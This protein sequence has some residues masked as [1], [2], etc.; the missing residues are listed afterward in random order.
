MDR[1]IARARIILLLCLFTAAGCSTCMAAENVHEL[2]EK[3]R[4]KADQN[5][6]DAGKFG[7]H[8]KSILKELSGDGKVEKQETKTF[9]TIW[10]EDKAYMELV[11]IDGKPLDTK[12]KKEEAERRKKFIETIHKKAKTEPDDEMNLTWEDLEKKYDFKELP[13]DGTSKYIISFTPRRSGLPE[14]NRM[15]RVINHVRGTIHVDE[16]YSIVSIDAELMESI[17]F[18][19]GILGRLDELQIKYSQTEFEN[20][21]VPDTLW[22]KYKARIL[23]STKRQEVSATFF[24][25]FPKDTPAA[26]K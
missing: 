22:F 21:F 4:K 5:E 18:G 15:E 26:S 13:P 12:H 16:S 1:Y 25:L 23:F 20:V 17:G 9:R 14:R 19:W 11:Q 8:Q 10:I 24:D 2:I 6:T 3:V 7:Y